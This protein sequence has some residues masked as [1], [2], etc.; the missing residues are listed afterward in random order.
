MSG[1]MMG[2][3]QARLCI[4]LTAFRLKIHLVS[5]T[6]YEFVDQFS[7]FL[8]MSALSSQLSPDIR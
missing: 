6:L 5:F 7:V 2:P 1:N 8:E 4:Q 3:S